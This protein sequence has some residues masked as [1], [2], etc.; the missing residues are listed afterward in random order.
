MTNFG[1]DHGD[2]IR[3]VDCRHCP[4]KAK[5]RCAAGRK[6]VLGL[7]YW[8]KCH[9]FKPAA[10]TS[11]PPKRERWQCIDARDG[12]LWLGTEPLW[13]YA[14]SHDS[15]AEVLAD[16]IAWLRHRRAEG[17]RRTEANRRRGT[18]QLVE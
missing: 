9:A 5:R 1:P 17:I 14:W 12:D 18:M 6:N 7:R 10:A 2:A 15:E 8:R 4:A 13:N 11:T 3:C 16:I